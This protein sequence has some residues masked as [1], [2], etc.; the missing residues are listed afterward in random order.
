[1]RVTEPEPRIH[2]IGERGQYRHRNQVSD[3]E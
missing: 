1:M 2:A 3:R